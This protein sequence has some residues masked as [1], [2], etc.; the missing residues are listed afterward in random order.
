MKPV[1]TIALL[2]LKNSP[3][4]K[5]TKVLCQQRKQERC[6]SVGKVMATT[7]ILGFSRNYLGRLLRRGKKNK[8]RVLCQFATKIE[9]QK[10][11]EMVLFGKKESASPSDNTPD[12]KS[13]NVMVLKSVMVS[14]SYFLCGLPLFLFPPSPFFNTSC[15]HL[16]FCILSTWRDT[17]LFVEFCNL[18]VY[19]SSE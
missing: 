7:Y 18:F 4:D 10:Q 15:L 6:F 16:A 13:T 11:R 19:S 8:L 5:H 12:H 1:S 3:N 17:W 2:E 14:S 9:R